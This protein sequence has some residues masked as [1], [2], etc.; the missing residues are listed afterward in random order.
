MKTKAGQ[1]RT[2]AM[3]MVSSPF[4]RNKGFEFDK[5]IMKKK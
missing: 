1:V 5:T 3:H 4:I 2:N